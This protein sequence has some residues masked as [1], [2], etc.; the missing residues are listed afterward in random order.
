MALLTLTAVDKDYKG[1]PLPY[2]VDF[3]IQVI[4]EYFRKWDTRSA[5]PLPTRRPHARL[6]LAT[7]TRFT[8]SAGVTMIE[9]LLPVDP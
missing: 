7:N 9:T 8:T 1:D 4:H 3:A 2:E 6:G 5:S